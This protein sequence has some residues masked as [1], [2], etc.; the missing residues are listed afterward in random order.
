LGISLILSYLKP[1]F[2][3]ESLISLPR[4]EGFEAFW[5]SR[6]SLGEQETKFYKIVGRLL[7]LEA[8]RKYCL[9]RGNSGMLGLEIS[10]LQV[11]VDMELIIS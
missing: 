8:P 9:L 11:N 3:D 2:S 5:R 10:F 6:I 4:F 1:S 7:F